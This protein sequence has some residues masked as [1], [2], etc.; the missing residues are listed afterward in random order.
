MKSSSV[1]EFKKNRDIFGFLYKKIDN[2][3][4]SIKI[5]IA[6]FTAFYFF[7]NV[8]FIFKYS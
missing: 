8:N 3:R 6:W 4:K 2:S 1:I 7:E 5:A